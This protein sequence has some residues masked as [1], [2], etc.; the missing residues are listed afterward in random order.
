MKGLASTSPAFATVGIS[1]RAARKHYGINVSRE[2]L[3]LEHDHTK[4]I[5]D[6]CSGFYRIFMMD[7][8]IEK[9]NLVKEDDPIRLN[10]RHTRLVSRGP[11]QT[12]S[13]AIYY[14][15]DPHNSGAPKY[16]EDEGV[17]QLVKVEADLSRIPAKKIPQT[18]GADGKMYYTIDYAIQVT[19][20][21]AYTSYE[22]IYGGVNYGHI[23][24]E[25]V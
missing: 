13:T 2:Y 19:Y 1:G 10:Y 4:R 7:W 25:Y 21:S 18:K 23:K 24:S 22:L 15:S 11:F 16:V 5:W 3:D 12:I 20:M 17:T 8:F 14:S 9:G 6:A